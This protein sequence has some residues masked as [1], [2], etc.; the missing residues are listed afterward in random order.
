MPA[1]GLLIEIADLASFLISWGI[2]DPPL[3]N[4]TPELEELQSAGSLETE[5]LWDRSIPNQ[6]LQS[7]MLQIIDNC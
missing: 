5:H 1:I 4:E 6:P 2:E 3:L 7:M